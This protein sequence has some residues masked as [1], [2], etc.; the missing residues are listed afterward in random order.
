MKLHART[1][2]YS[3]ALAHPSRLTRLQQERLAHRHVALAGGGT[4]AVRGS[5]VLHLPRR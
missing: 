5:V 4:Q 2:A 3:D 1:Q